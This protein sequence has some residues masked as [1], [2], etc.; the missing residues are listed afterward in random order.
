MFDL[1]NE[2][3]V[4]NP[5]IKGDKI[6]EVFY[7]FSFK[8]KKGKK[9]EMKRQMRSQKEKRVSSDLGLY[10]SGRVL[11]SMCALIPSCSDLT[12]MDQVSVLKCHPWIGK[13]T[14]TVLEDL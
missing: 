14:H 12:Q 13:L 1:R 9:R 8:K 2:K 10:L 4:E 3:L 11:R 7:T 6:A 5:F